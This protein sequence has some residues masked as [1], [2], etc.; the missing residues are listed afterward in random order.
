MSTRRASCGP[1]RLVCWLSPNTPVEPWWRVSCE[2][3]VQCC[4]DCCCLFPLLN[5]HD[6]RRTRSGCAAKPRRILP[7]A[8]PAF[9][10]HSALCLREPVL[11]PLRPPPRC[12]A[13]VRDAV[14]RPGGGVA[15]AHGG[16]GVPHDASLRRPGPC[17]HLVG[18]HQ[19]RLR[20]GQGFPRGVCGGGA[21]AAGRL[22]PAGA[23]D[24]ALELREHG[25]APGGT[26]DGEVRVRWRAG[27]RGWQ[28]QPAGGCRH[29]W[30]RAA[31]AL[32]LFSRTCADGLRSCCP[33]GDE[34]R[35]A[36]RVR[37]DGAG[38][39]GVGVRHPGPRAVG[40]VAGPL[41]GGVAGQARSAARGEDKGEATCAFQL[42]ART[43]PHRAA[44]CVQ[45]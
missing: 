45:N 9:P 4:A 41:H 27:W 10:R 6:H 5:A 22:R 28:C 44:P 26:L 38:H 43:C 42:V 40:G 25:G 11:T 14:A 8:A 21:G 17:Q 3:A 30:L 37:L 33:Q 18:A 32:P 35:A 24:D 12:C 2:K 23:V 13:G 34:P 20:P 15:A 36:A 1:A 16:G 7:P 19:H 39:H 31:A 29:L